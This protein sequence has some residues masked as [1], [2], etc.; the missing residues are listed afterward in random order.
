[1]TVQKKKKRLD[2]CTDPHAVIYLFLHQNSFARH[3][4]F[5]DPEYRMPI[6][7]QNSFSAIVSM[8]L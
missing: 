5:L 7:K 4:A 8:V 6:T 3:G 1:M 2:F